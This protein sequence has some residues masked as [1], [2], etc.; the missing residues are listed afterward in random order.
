MD[1]LAKIKILNEK[2]KNIIRLKEDYEKVPQGIMRD[3]SKEGLEKILK[4]DYTPATIKNFFELDLTSFLDKI[5]KLKTM[6]RE[7]SEVLKEEYD[8]F[9]SLDLV[10][11]SNSVLNEYQSNDLAKNI[12][13]VLRSNITSG[14]RNIFIENLHKV[15]LIE[16]DGAFYI[17]KKAG[18]RYTT[19]RNL[20]GVSGDLFKN[21]EFMNDLISAYYKGILRINL[22]DNIILGNIEVN[23]KS[24]KS[25]EYKSEIHSA[26]SFDV[27]IPLNALD[28][29]DD[30]TNK[31]LKINTELYNLG[32]L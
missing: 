6:R 18:L 5:L 32:I 31:V 3:L 19:F 30:I 7:D 4:K 8:K 20:K 21:V 28:V 1:K 23:E 26:Y 27:L 2:G 15:Q 16:Q 10:A 29:A 9:K 24:L 25:K 17:L 14:I 11:L 22:G 12:K 13:A